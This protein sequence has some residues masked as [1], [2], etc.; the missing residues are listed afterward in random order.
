MNDVDKKI[1]QSGIIP[2]VVIDDENKAIPLTNALI[3]GGLDIIEITFRTKKAKEVINI[4][5]SNFPDV[6]VG[7][8]TILNIEQAKEAIEC[9]AK[10]IVSPGFDEKLVKYCLDNKIPVYPGIQTASELTKAIGYG[11]QIVKIFPIEEM[12]GI[13]MVN[14]LGAAFPN[15]KFMPTGGINFDN[16][17][18]YFKSKKVIA[19]GGSFIV[20]KDLIKNNEFEKI[21]SLTKDTINKLLGFNLK[22]IGI[23]CANEEESISEVKKIEALFGF[24]ERKT[25]QS[26]FARNEIEFMNEKGRGTNGH[27]A[28][29]CN[30]V[31]RAYYYLTKRGYEFDEDSKTFDE[32]GNL[33]LI[34]LKK[35]YAGFAYHLI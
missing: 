16:V 33:R 15:V 4:I 21:T 8:G 32:S 19:I 34:Y 11:I 1:Y 29:G 24:K 2:V 3:N 10:Y 6:L 13:K 9:G 22:H 25:S 18:D 27:I 26:Y 7:A 35:E 17:D 30:N 28:I 20:K 12:G 5:S 23:N 14:A 31:D